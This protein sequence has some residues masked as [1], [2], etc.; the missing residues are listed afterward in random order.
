MSI[1]VVADVMTL[2]ILNISGQ[3]WTAV[4]AATQAVS[5]SPTWGDAWLTLARCQVCS[6]LDADTNTS[7]QLQEASGCSPMSQVA[8]NCERRAFDS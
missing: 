2:Q 5:L 8:A 1:N 3:T 6:L 4:Q 7:E